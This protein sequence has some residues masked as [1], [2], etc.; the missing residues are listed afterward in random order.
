MISPQLQAEINKYKYYPRWNCSFPPCVEKHY[1]DNLLVYYY[2]RANSDNIYCDKY[3]PDGAQSTLIVIR[4]DSQL[5][6]VKYD[7]TILLDRLPLLLE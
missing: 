5:V 3:Y 7:Q 1:F 2:E 6:F 4:F